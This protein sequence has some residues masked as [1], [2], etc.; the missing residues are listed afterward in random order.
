MSC[1]RKTDDSDLEEYYAL[2][3]SG[4]NLKTDYS[5]RI[6]TRKSMSMK[7]FC[8]GELNVKEMEH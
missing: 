8:D 6:L 1:K 5:Y 4:V 2:K 3:R 7:K